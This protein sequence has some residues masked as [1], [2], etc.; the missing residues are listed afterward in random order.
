MLGLNDYRDSLTADYREWNKKIAE[1][2]ESYYKAVPDGKFIIL[3]R[4]QPV[5]RSTYQRRFYVTAECSHMAT[6]KKYH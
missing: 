6:A 4:V 1:M 2:K 3:I 5:V